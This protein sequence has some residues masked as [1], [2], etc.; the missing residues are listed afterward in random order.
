ME[1]YS[2][3]KASAL[4][5]PAS[6]IN[7]TFESESSET[8]VGIHFDKIPQPSPFLLSP[9]LSTPGTKGLVVAAVQKHLPLLSSFQA[10]Q[11]DI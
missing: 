1:I 5:T 10:M 6:L 7:K 11:L 8:E 3:S 9:F 2:S 4:N